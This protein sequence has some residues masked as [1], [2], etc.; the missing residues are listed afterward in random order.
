MDGEMHF[1]AGHIMDP[2]TGDRNDSYLTSSDH[3]VYLKEAV[4]QMAT[5]EFTGAVPGDTS[6]LLH[7]A[8][9]RE[10]SNDSYADLTDADEA[11][12]LLSENDV[13]I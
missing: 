5:S 1:W 4:S 12:A 2:V 7:Q 6:D 8:L 10:N 3:A 9:I 13:R 11:S